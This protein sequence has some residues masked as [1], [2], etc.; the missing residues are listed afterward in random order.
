MR[1]ERIQELPS[2]AGLLRLELTVR[3][4]AYAANEKLDH[5]TSRGEMPVLVYRRSECG[6]YHGN[7]IPAS[8]RAILRRPAWLRRLQKVHSQGN[9]AL[10]K[11]DGV[12]RELDS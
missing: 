1:R 7:F 9:H 3:N 4:A 10:P 6:R 8:Y 5:V 11:A 2:S 12:W